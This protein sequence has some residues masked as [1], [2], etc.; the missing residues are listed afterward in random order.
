MLLGDR[1]K[2]ARE[3]LRPKMTQGALGAVFGISDKAVS[4]WERNETVP[5]VDKLPILRSKL[6]VSFAWLLTGD[7]PPPAPDD[8]EVQ[9]DDLRSRP[10]PAKVVM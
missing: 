5:E 3:R 7:G 10:S 6:R 4:S 9:L 2:L 8:A 1:I